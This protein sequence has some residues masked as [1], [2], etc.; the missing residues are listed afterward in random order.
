MA[1]SDIRVLR[2]AEL[3]AFAAIVR[4]AY[5]AFAEANDAEMLARLHRRQQDFPGSTLV[6]LFRDGQ[7]L[8]G[9]RLFDF[10]M[11]L[12]EQQA[13]IGGVGLVA[14]D[15]RHKK[16]GV[17]REL[18]HYF[19]HQY[20]DRG[21]SLVS[22]YPFRP[23]FYRR[24]GFGYGSPMY[25][26]TL[27]PAALPHQGDRS[28]VRFLQRSDWPALHAC[29]ERCFARMHGLYKRSADWIR[30]WL[31]ETLANSRNRVIGYWQGEELEAYLV[32]AFQPGTTFLLNSILVHEMLAEHSVAYS[33]LLSFLHFQYDQIQKIVLDTQDEYFYWCLNDVRDGSDGL[34]PPV[35]H[36]SHQA[37]IGLMYRLINTAGFFAALA[38]HRFGPVD[39]TLAI[40]VRDDFLAEQAGTTVVRFRDGRPQVL[41][42][43]SS[44]DVR[45]VLDGADF[46]ALA[47]GSV[48]FGALQRLG[49]A[50]ISDES[51]ST[52]VQ[53]TF[54]VHQRP[55][56]L[57]RF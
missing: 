49:L 37:G 8:G 45:I 34:I 21:A 2:D 13:L 50:A 3:P 22:L 29:Y 26:Y 6:G 18:I 16:E 31:E 42:A 4:N 51:C 23:D 24:M 57:T 35:Y 30:R 55:I 14:V 33:G 44:A 12:F 53:Q 40:D 41:A 17:A 15:M 19:L 38:N 43:G 25:R 28:R 46:A 20:R 54:Y 47:L 52:L 5:P 7:L 27:K 32:F 1:N 56:C 36:S 39:Y 10:E 9:M 48:E 11:R